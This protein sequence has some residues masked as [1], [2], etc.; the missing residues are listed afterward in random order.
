MIEVGKPAVGWASM[1]WAAAVALAWTFCA[2][3]PARALD[4]PPLVRTAALAA[5]DVS[6]RIDRMID[7][8]VDLHEVHGLPWSETGSL[9]A[10]LEEALIVLQDGRCADTARQLGGFRDRVA[11][12]MIHGH[13][14]PA[15][16]APVL[17][18]NDDLMH[19]VDALCEATA[20]AAEN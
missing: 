16:A 8:V 3:A 5:P 11:E 15:A 1:A 17:A 10:V 18:A 12:H 19:R 6:G 4:D 2:A 7:R 20:A 9:I 14:E 13:L